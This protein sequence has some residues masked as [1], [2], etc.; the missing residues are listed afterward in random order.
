M[1]RIYYHI[2]G[3]R[4]KVVLQACP[5]QTPELFEKWFQLGLLSRDGLANLLSE[6]MNVQLQAQPET[7]IPVVLPVNKA[8]Q[9]VVENAGKEVSTKDVVTEIKQEKKEREE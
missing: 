5:M 9:F 3:E 8:S 1:E 4:C 7:S 2:Y 6:A